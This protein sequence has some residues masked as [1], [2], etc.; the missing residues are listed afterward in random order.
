[1]SGNL[2]ESNALHTFNNSSKLETLVD[3]YKGGE[4]VQSKVESCLKQNEQRNLQK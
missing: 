4:D 2:E 1:M 3:N